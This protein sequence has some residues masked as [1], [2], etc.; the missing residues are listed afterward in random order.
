MHLTIIAP[1]RDIMIAEQPTW[2]R[3]AIRLRCGLL[4]KPLSQLGFMVKIIF[5]PSVAA[6]LEDGSLFDTDLFWLC[7]APVDY[8]RLVKHL[9]AAGKPIIFDICD[10]IFSMIGHAKMNA[11]AAQTATAVTVSSQRLKA[12]SETNLSCPVHYLGDATEGER[13]PAKRHRQGPPQLIWFGWQHK[14]DALIE[15]LP[16]LQRFACR[17]PGTRLVCLTNLNYRTDKMHFLN[18][19][20]NDNLK[21]DILPWDLTSFADEVQN[22]DLVLIP[23]H[24]RLSLSGKSN[25]RLNQAF[26]AGRMPIV[27]DHVNFHEYA[28]FQCL[29]AD[30]AAGLDW[31][32]EHPQTVEQAVVAAQ[33]HIAKTSLPAAIAPRAKAIFETVLIAHHC[34]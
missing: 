13:M 1:P 28:K 24:P 34:R 17:H 19:G 12:I 16:D 9:Q 30:F 5:V 14:L 15:K 8:R 23:D 4:A 18:Q 7:H 31:A 33:V 32:I 27:E 20:T 29:H 11:E 22:S 25:N 10:N 3:A 26:W 2:I 6:R 21:I